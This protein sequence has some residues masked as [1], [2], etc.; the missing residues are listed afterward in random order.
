MYWNPKS[1]VKVKVKSTFNVH[2]KNFCLKSS[3][4]LRVNFFSFV[5][6]FLNWMKGIDEM[7]SYWFNWNKNLTFFADHEWVENRNERIAS[8]W[9]SKLKICWG[10]EIGFESC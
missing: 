8:F 1:K 3:A 10:D 2:K 7:C 9:E 4:I 5:N 6:Y